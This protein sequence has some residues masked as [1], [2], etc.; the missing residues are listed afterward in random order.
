M[1]I[2]PFFDP[3]PTPKGKGNKSIYLSNNAGLNSLETK[4]AEI[5]LNLIEQNKNMNM[6][7]PNEIM[8]VQ[9]KMITKKN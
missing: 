5:H 3:H 2:V 8:N 1:F 7:L 4:L 9:E 6:N